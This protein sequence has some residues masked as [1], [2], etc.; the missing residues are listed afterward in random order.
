LRLRQTRQCLFR[1]RHESCGIPGSGSA[2]L[3]CTAQSVPNLRVTE[4]GNTGEVRR[5]PPGR[6]LLNLAALDM[7]DG[8]ALSGSA[9]C[10]AAS[11]P[12]GVSGSRGGGVRDGTPCTA[13]ARSA[14]HWHHRLSTAAVAGA[15]QPT[16]AT[17][18]PT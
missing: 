13:N 17:T 1:P 14:S 4:Q 7:N 5:L 10:C 3:P 15:P 9:L 18:S 6:G 16:A 8:V 2:S 12:S 11:R